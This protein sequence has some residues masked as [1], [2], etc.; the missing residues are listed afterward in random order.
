MKIA[1]RSVFYF[2]SSLLLAATNISCTHFE[3]TPESGY[4]AFQTP[5]TTV[6]RTK[7]TP[8]E[9][10]WDSA[11]YKTRVKQ[12]ENG[13]RGKRELDQYSH[14][15][16]LFKNEQE[17]IEFLQLQGFENRARWVNQ[18]NVL[19][20]SQTQQD[21]MRD[22]V[23]AQDIAVGMPLTLVKK[24]WGD[25]E[26]IEISGSPEFHNERWRYAKYVSTPDG[27]K[28]ERKIVYFEGGKV[29][30]WEVE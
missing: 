21:D 20:R 3:R 24:S 8:R 28:L 4:A 23:D 11:Q 10:N 26:H 19:K 1:T 5:K 27:Y 9:E 30:G 18:K 15:L 29:V 16:P 14:L 7:A 2:A 22:L 6:T 13:L 12:L 25:P 17:K